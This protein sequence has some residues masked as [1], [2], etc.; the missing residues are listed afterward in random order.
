MLGGIHAHR[1]IGASVI[2]QISLPVPVKMGFILRRECNGQRTGRTRRMDRR[3]LSAGGSRRSSKP[4]APAL[5]QTRAQIW[6]QRYGAPCTAL[7]TE[8]HIFDAIFEREFDAGLARLAYLNDGF[9][10]LKDVSDPYVLFGQSFDR[11]ILS[12]V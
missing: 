7:Y 10:Q 12:E 6:H 11:Y 2:L 8:H 4:A 9:P 1:F 3:R 5:R